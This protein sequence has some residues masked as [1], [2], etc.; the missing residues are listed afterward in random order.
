[1]ASKRW[2]LVVPVFLLG[3]ASVKSLVA[4]IN[5]RGSDRRLVN[6]RFL[7]KEQELAHHL[8]APTWLPY[9][10]RIGDSGPTQGANR[11]LQDFTDKDDRTLLILAQERRSTERDRYHER[12]FQQ[13][14]EAKAKFNGKSGYFVTGTGGER[15]LFWNEADT[16]VILSTAVLTDEELLQVA[17]KVQ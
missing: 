2:L 10:G 6:A 12:L 17:Q 5:V 7:E 11:L 8:Y 1:M 15:R 9:N 14:A 4:G 3:G 13:R 16:A